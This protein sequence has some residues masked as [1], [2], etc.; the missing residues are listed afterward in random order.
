MFSSQRIILSFVFIFTYALLFWGIGAG[1]V[2][3]GWS[4]WGLVMGAVVGFIL[5]IITY[6]YHNRILLHASKAKPL[7][8]ARYP[9]VHDAVKDFCGK[10]GLPVPNLYCSNDLLPDF[11]VFGTSF[12]KCIFVFTQGFLDEGRPEPLRAA[13][14]WTMVSASRGSLQ[15][16]TVGSVMAY[17][18]MYPAKIADF[19]SRGTEARYN[20]VKLIILLPLAPVAALFIH[21]ALGGKS[22]IY[23]TDE[24]TTELTGD[25][26]YLGV[27]LIEISKK[28]SNFVM[29]TDLAL[30]PLFIAPPRCPNIYY[31]LFRPFPPIAKRINRLIKQREYTRK[32]MERKYNQ[33]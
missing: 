7:K 24:R 33:K 12:E 6:R 14:A 18:F 13:L 8:P 28:I 5:L 9:H 15:T 2:L 31:N 27:T 3:F 17:M 16:R 30:I 25:Q 4:V 23:T 29:D 10:Y 21:L 32:G 26:G 19:I 20:L 22:E 11:C 1:K